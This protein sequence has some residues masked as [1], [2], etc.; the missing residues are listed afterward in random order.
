MQSINELLR[1]F[2]TSGGRIAAAAILFAMIWGIKNIPWVKAKVL[3]SDRSKLVV[4]V[5]TGM[6]PATLM[7]MDQSVPASEAWS[8]ALMV[9]LSAMGVQGAFKAMVGEQ[10]KKKLRLG[11]AKDKV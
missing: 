8:N 11:E 9:L 10:L 4:T 7:L 3:T 6:A 5:I 1:W 2:M